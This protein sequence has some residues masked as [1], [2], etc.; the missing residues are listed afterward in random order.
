MLGNLSISASAFAGAVGL[1]VVGT[2][3]QLFLAGAASAADTGFPGLEIFTH[4]DQDT[5]GPDAAGLRFSGPITAPLADALETV[6]FDGGKPRFARLMLELDS[7]GGELGAVE[8]VVAVLEKVKRS[9]TLNTRVLDGKVCASGCVALFMVGSQRKASTASVW[10]FHG[11]HYLNSNV[12]ALDQTQRY[13]ELL[14]SLG[15]KPDF[16]RTLA[17]DGYVTRPGALILSSYE[18]FHN[19]DT[20]I[21]TELQ[22]NWRPE[23]PYGVKPFVSR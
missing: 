19:Y 7:E 12:P 9:A 18:L 15:V 2:L 3:G 6:L 5:I 20:G 4:K 17:V 1:L 22:P 16:I 21:I 10:V 13:L 23:K 8:K 14:V 11:A